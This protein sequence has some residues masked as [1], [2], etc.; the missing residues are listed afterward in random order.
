MVKH[1]YQLPSDWYMLPLVSLGDVNA[2]AP[3]LT[4]EFETLLRF[5]GAGKSEAVRGLAAGMVQPGVAAAAQKVPDNICLRYSAS[6]AVTNGLEECMEEA[7]HEE[8]SS[9][10]EVLEDAVL[11]ILREIGEDPDRQVKTLIAIAVQRGLPCPVCMACSAMA[12]SAAC[13]SY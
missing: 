7:E 10:S 8:G 6:S 13:L 1:A 9:V 5:S 2:Q 12:A 3:C 4:Q 11:T